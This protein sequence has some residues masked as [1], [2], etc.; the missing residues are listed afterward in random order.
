MPVHRR[1]SEIVRT[2]QIALSGTILR[3]ASHIRRSDP[4]Q[5]MNPCAVMIRAKRFLTDVRMPCGENFMG[6][7]FPSEAVA[8]RWDGALQARLRRAPLDKFLRARAIVPAPA[9]VAQDSDN[10]VRATVLIVEAG[11]THYFNDRAEGLAVPQRPI[12]GHVA[13]VVSRALAELISQPGSWRIAALVSTA[14]LLSPWIGLNS[15]ALEAASS[16]R[17]FQQEWSKAAS[18]IDERVRH[19]A[20]TA[21]TEESA[22]RMAEVSAIIAIRLSCPVD[23]EHPAH[24]APRRTQFRVL[25]RSLLLT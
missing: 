8:R 19:S 12:V 1:L 24:G 22:A 3:R 2:R 14:R 13:C 18:A 15:A 16:A 9:G 21:V 5:V 10:L 6:I 11:L 20:L 17:W 7:L 23:T 4:R 25:D